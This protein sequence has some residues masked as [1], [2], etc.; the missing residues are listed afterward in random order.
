[1]SS[2]IQVILSEAE[3]EA[4]RRQA[5]ARKMSLSTWLLEA[6]RKQL[7]AEQ[8]GPLR[9]VAELREFFGSL[10]DEPGVEP[11]WDEHLRVM[12]ESRRHG[13]SAP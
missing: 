8:A 10:P 11:D 9:T 13:A 7:A 5:A 12:A 6:G 4:F 2:R 3:R 1:M